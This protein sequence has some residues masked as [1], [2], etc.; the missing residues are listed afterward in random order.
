MPNTTDALL[1]RNRQLSAG[2]ALAGVAFAVVR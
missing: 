1:G 2:V